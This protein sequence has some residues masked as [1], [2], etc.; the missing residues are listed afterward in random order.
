MRANDAV[1]QGIV[2]GVA[3]LHPGNRVE[4]LRRDLIG[5]WLQAIIGLDTVTA[6]VSTTL[7]GELRGE[8]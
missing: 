5:H 6:G 1:L 3:Y 4:Q 8:G 7:G 2:Q